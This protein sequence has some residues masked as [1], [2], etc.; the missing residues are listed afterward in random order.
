[1]TDTSVSLG[2]PVA[3]LRRQFP[4]LQRDERFI[5]F[6]NAAGA[7]I[8]SRVL[9][10][11][12]SHL[13]SR[14]VQRGGVYR[15]S[16]EVDAMLARTR[17]SVAALVN[18]RAPDE[19]AFGLNATSFIRAISLAVGQALGVRNEIVVTDIDHEANVATWLAL[20]RF[21][22]RITW[23]PVRADGRLH[24]ED[25]EAIVSERT[26]LVACTMASNA[27]GTRVDAG[28]AAAAARRVGAEVFLD[29]V[30]LA[31]HAAI[32]VQALGAD[33]L[34]CSGYKLFSPHMGFAWCRRDAINSLPT[35]REDFIPDV[36]PDKLEAGTYAYEN[37]AGMEAVVAYL[38][39]VAIRVSDGS[40]GRSR[41]DRIERAFSAIAQYE[42][43]L[44]AAL[45]DAIER[46][47]GSTVHGV[48]AGEDLGKRVPTVSFTID[49]VESSALAAALAAHDVGV[50]SGH[51]YAPRLMRRLGVP[52]GGLV[53]AS[54]VHYNTVAEI[55]R[56]GSILE[57]AVETLRSKG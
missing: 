44:S 45:L 19:I 56:F 22:A 13:V 14:N 2:F 25:L 31:P 5:F 29:A 24:V 55:A 3:E 7:Q 54:L 46:V 8:P 23:W 10:A 41:R 36:T 4:G 9:E 48:R 15:H 17:E 40:S 57:E 51:M 33:Y 11:I 32:D 43:D 1:M 39:D 18:A 6:D 21:G 52:A 26:R 30:H 28:A 49:G 20:E 35:F 27:T 16:Q 50:R 47:P 38:E 53:R 42:R 34:V 12:T 37:V